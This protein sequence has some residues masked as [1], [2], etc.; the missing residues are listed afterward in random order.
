MVIDNYS[1]LFATISTIRY[2]GVSDPSFETIGTHTIRTI[3]YSQLCA[4]RYSSFPDTP[5]IVEIGR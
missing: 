1:R 3:P 2:S 5:G 4:V